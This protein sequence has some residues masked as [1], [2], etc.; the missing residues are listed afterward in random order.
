MWTVPA[1]AVAAAKGAAAELAPI[2]HELGD[3]L[4]PALSGR[5]RAAEELVGGVLAA[6]EHVWQ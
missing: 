2:L 4:F 5:A 3:G 1:E 6:L